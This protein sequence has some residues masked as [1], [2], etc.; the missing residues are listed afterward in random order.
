MAF[1]MKNPFPGM[2]PWLEEYWRDVH[3]HLLVYAC[4]SL[5]GELPGSLR[6]R[7]DERLSID[8]GIGKARTYIPDLAVTES[9][10]NPPTDVL[11][12]GGLAVEVAQPQIVELGEVKLRRLEIIDARENIITVIELLSRSNKDE[13][14]NRNEWTRKR[15][16]HLLAGVN[17]VEIDLLRGGG[18]TL[19]DR[20]DLRPVPPERV[21]Y[22]VCATRPPR[23]GRHEFYVM[24]LR[25][26]LPTIRV[27]LRRG[28]PDAALNLQSLIDQCYAG[29]RYGSTLR[30]EQQPAPPLPPEELA[31]AREILAAK[32]E[33]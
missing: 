26:R 11:G 31:W 16:E 2:N 6:A 10:D 1:A 29:G 3:S 22:H 8:F 24:P 27:P 12:P 4:D 21:C 20:S 25:E 19:P 18:W 13:P 32:S 15:H 14:D 33:R 17:F 7:I 23:Y 28:D 30:Y 9:W 5:N